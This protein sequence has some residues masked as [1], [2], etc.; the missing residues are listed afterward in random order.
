MEVFLS[1]SGSESRRVAEALKPWLKTLFPDL[2]VWMSCSDIQV[3][4]PWGTAL[5]EQL[6]RTDFG[7]LCLTAENLTAPWVLYEAGALAM[8]SKVGCVVPYLLGVGPEKLP[9]PLAQFQSVRAN[10]EGTWKFVE[11]INA[12]FG[13][14]LPEDR[15]SA[16]F[17]REWSGLAR[18]LGLTVRTELHGDVMVVTP[19][20]RTLMYD[21]EVHVLRE[22]IRAI[23]KGGQKRVVVDLIEVTEFSSMGLTILPTGLLAR[24]QKTGE[25]VFVNLAPKVREALESVKLLNVVSHLPTLDDALAHFRQDATTQPLPSQPTLPT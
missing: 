7:V 4:T 6:K 10:R 1:W 19:T 5:H 18:T 9:A 25:V 14:L 24:Q 17:A 2:E 20:S 15:L 11:R 23:L 13:G 8:S 22:K 21:E 3:G 16:V 12:G